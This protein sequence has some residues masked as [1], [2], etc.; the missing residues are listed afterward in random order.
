MKTIK[1]I[2]Y[3]TLL[4]ATLLACSSSRPKVDSAQDYIPGKV[5]PRNIVEKV[6]EENGATGSA[7]V[8]GGLYTYTL[9]C[10]D[11]K[12][13]TKIQHIAGDKATDAELDTIIPKI[14]AE[15]DPLNR[16]AKKTLEESCEGSTRLL[17][18]LK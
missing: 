11:G 5:Y 18:Y 8:D 17:T 15:L 7:Y 3:T 1:N 4:A 12:I 6:A 16:S 10:D 9:T 2:I 13:S 14:E